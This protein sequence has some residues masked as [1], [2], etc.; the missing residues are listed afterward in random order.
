MHI[1]EGLLATST[2]GLLVMGA[3]AVVAAAGTAIGLRRLDY[4]RMPQAAMLSATF[5]VASLIHVPLGFTSVHL[6]LNGL[7]GLI[8]GWAAFPVLLVGLVLQAVFFGFGGPMTLGINTT[9]MA[10]PAV[11]CHYLFRRATRAQSDAVV[12]TAAV[13]AGSLAILLSASLVCL[14]LIASGEH[15]GLVWK[16]VLVA[17]LPVAAVE[18][19]VTASAVAFLRKVRPELLETPLLVPGALEVSDG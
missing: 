18:G 12:T 8:L 13:A 11:A 16:L 6:V 14:A 15:F 3:G 1:D 17:H 10:L 2:P 4:E 5:F 7:V 19:L 9:A